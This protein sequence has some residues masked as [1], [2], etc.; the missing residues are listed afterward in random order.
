MPRKNRG[1]SWL[2]VREPEKRPRRSHSACMP[3]RLIRVANVRKLAVEVA[4]DQTVARVSW[5]QPFGD[6]WDATYVCTK[7]VPLQRRGSML[8]G[9]APGPVS[10]DEVRLFDYSRYVL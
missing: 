4:L 8:L 7:N 10:V 2:I 1:K 9:E 3:Q 6:T 5:L